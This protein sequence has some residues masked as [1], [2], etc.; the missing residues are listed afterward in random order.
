MGN[1][2][3]HV[4]V[5]ASIRRDIRIVQVYLC[6]IIPYFQFNTLLLLLLLYYFTFIY[7]FGKFL[8][9]KHSVLKLR[10][11]VSPKVKKKKRFQITR[12]VIS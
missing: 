7:F 2:N 1:N 12:S 9:Q 4:F 5:I 11:F 10:I 6:R 8:R 3:K